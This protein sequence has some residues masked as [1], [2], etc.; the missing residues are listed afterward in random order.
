MTHTYVWGPR[1][2]MPGAAHA[3]TWRCP[4]CGKDNDPQMLWCV[5]CGWVR[6]ALRRS[7]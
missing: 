5:L 1:G 7:K 3:H 6:N 2:N 4:E